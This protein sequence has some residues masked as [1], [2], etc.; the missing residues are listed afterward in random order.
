MAAIYWVAATLLGLVL[1]LVAFITLVVE[2]TGRAI[3]VAALVIG[4]GV[5]HALPRRVHT[6]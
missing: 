6:A 1:G 4:A 2:Y 3:G 5:A